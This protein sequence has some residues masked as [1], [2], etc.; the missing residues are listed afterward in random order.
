MTVRNEDD[1]DIEIRG[2]KADFFDECFLK[3]RYAVY[4]HSRG[5]VRFLKECKEKYFKSH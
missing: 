1:L 4:I 5:D 2:K 3:L